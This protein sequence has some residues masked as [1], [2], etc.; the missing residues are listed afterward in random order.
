[1]AI[2]GFTGPHLEE[3][4]EVLHG[5]HYPNMVEGAD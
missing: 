5:Y 1:M 2:F 4:G 3:L